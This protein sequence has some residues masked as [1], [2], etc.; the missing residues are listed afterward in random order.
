MTKNTNHKLSFSKKLKKQSKLL[1]FCFY[2]IGI[3]Y[4]GSLAYATKSI[5]S[6]ERIETG[7]RVGVLIVLYL[8]LLFYIL[9]GIILLFTK[10]TKRFILCLLIT[11]LLS[12]G[13]SFASY[14]VSKTMNI[15]NQVQKKTVKYTSVM[16]SLKDT[17]EFDKIGM[18]NS[19][20]DPTGYT[21][22]KEMIKKYDIDGKIEK[23]SDYI[24]MVN[25]LYEKKIDAMFV[26]KEYEKMFN[27]YEKFAN[28]KEETKEVYKLTKEMKNVDNVSYSSKKLTEPFTVLLMGV[29]GT[30]DGINNASSFNGDSLMLI[31]FNPKTLSA[32]MFSI[33]RD[34]YVPIACNGNKKNKIN[35]SAYGGTSCVVKTI[36]NLT[37]I[38]I[39]Y[40]VKINF[41]GVVTLV[42]DLGKITVDVPMKFCEQDSER[43][44]GEYELCLNP[45]VQELNGE[46]ALALARHR[47]TLPLGDFQ[48]VQ[49][50]QLVVEAMAQKVREVKDVDAFYKILNDV[51]RNI[52][53][54]MSTSQILSFYQVMKDVMVNKLNDSASISIQKTY[55]TGYDLTMYIPGMGNVY[56]FQYYKNS[57]KDI[58]NYMEINLEKKKP[59]MTKKF[60]FSANE[61]YELYVAGKGNYAKEAKI[62]G[63]VPNFIGK[64]RNYVA[65]WAAARGI[66]VYY[67][68]VNSSTGKDGE[69]ISQSVSAGTIIDN[70]NYI[71]ITVVQ[72]TE[73]T[74]I[75]STETETNRE[76]TEDTSRDNSNSDDNSSSGHNTGGN[77]SSDNGNNNNQTPSSDTPPSNPGGGQ[78]Q[79]GDTPPDNPGGGQN[80]GGG[81]T[82]NPNDPTEGE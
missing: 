76:S 20:N 74:E 31:T 69:V 73:T 24:S 72:R 34:T 9:G 81:N 57:L 27:S 48:R 21:V 59:K 3:I 80:Q 18:I 29:D 5:L 14:Y 51:T 17:E 58:V 37:G 63:T 56:T 43:R 22:P 77:G 62:G 23:Y 1:R 55:L 40:Y 28:I 64:D 60:S 38:N 8:W 32:T 70:L 25:D 13:L 66:A 36:Q 33:P 61:K 45:G 2:L 16:L 6:L 49:H 67:N 75:E 26:S 78:N 35:S 53:T 10:R 41:T 52:D 68:V 79:S 42:N 39:D 82:E 30:G 44:F 50:Q 47:H 7:I 11:L 19:K 15:I 12:G 4:I 71:T 65:N 54:N 46:Q